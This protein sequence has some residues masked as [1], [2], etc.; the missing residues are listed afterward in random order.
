MKTIL[1]VEDDPIIIQVYRGPLVGGG[2]RVEVAED[3]LVAMRV[4]PQLRPDLV[5]LDIMLPKINGP[6]VLKYIR[7][8]PELSAT[9][10][11]VLS[12]ATDVAAAKEMVAL[13]P[14]G[15]FL[16]S[17]M[18]PR[19]L[20]KEISVLLNGGGTATPSENV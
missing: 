10:V 5:V 11:I 16:K 18:T 2:Y 3:G 7:S 19:E 9:K 12:D 17:H 15:A 6:Y 20:L 4:M 13:N 1:F 8:R 14:D